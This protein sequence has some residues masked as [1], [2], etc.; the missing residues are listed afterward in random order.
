MKLGT[1]LPRKAQE[2]CSR[3]N[4]FSMPELMVSSFLFA[5]F[6]TLG[7]QL[8]NS[9]TDGMKRTNLRSKVDSAMALRMDE[10]RH[11]AF[12]Y[13]LDS[14]LLIEGEDC[15]SHTFDLT[16]QLS[17]KLDTLA[18]LCAANTIGNSFSNHLSNNGLG[19]NFNLQDYDSS[20]DSETI[21]TILT[22]AGN[23]LRVSLSATSIPLSIQSTI[24]PH[25]QGWCR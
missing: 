18:P 20:A 24:V 14:S 8:T 21:E 17:Y 9:T 2:Q 12:F 15:R 16:Q 22:P 3:S 6:V 7:T 5:T 11:C 25:A 19:G 23:Q 4:G 1:L 10:I 13:L